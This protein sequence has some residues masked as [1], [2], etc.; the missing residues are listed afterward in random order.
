MA[1]T[2]TA[3][4]DELVSGSPAG[5][6]K[7]WNWHPDIPIQYSPLFSYP[8]HPLAVCKWFISAWLPLTEL[9]IYLLIAIL[10]WNGIQPPLAETTTLEFGWVSALWARNIIMMTAI[11]TILHLWLYRW[12]KQGN[13]YRFMRTS[14]TAENRKFLG[15]HQLRDNIFWVLVSGVTIWSLYETGFWLAYANGIAPMISFP[16]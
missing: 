15:G 10:V 8:L 9:T 13:D 14:P 4:T 7:S 3:V 1:I 11:A 16:V 5:E 6:S 12:H 2:D